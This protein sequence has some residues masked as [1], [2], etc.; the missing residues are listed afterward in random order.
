M[1]R[2]ILLPL[3]TL[4][5]L[6]TVG[7]LWAADSLSLED[8]SF[9]VLG[10][11]ID[12]PPVPIDSQWWDGF[13]RPGADGLVMSFVLHDGDVVVGGDFQGIGS[14]RS[15]GIARW[16]GSDWASL[17]SDFR[18]VRVLGVYDGDVIAG[19]RC[20][21]GGQ[22]IWHWDGSAWQRIG[23][24][25][26]AWDGGPGSGCEG[27]PHYVFALAEY[28]GRLFAG[29]WFGT[30]T[31]NPDS[32]ILQWN[33]ETWSSL[34]STVNAGVY[35]MTL[36][37]GKLVVGGRFTQAGEVGANRIATWDG[38]TWSA[39]G[40]GIDDDISDP[41][42]SQRVKALTVYEGNLYA[43]GVFSKAGSF[44]VDRLA[45]WD[46]SSWNSTGFEA[47][48]YVDGEVPTTN[49]LAVYD[50]NLVAGGRFRQ[51]DGALADFIACWDGESWT[52]LGSGLDG[53]VHALIPFDDV[54]LVGGDFTHAGNQLVYNMAMWDGEAWH[55][56]GYGQGLDRKAKSLHVHNDRLIVGGSFTAAGD[57][58]V[59]RIAGWDGSSWTPLGE[60][61]V[62]KEKSV[63]AL[64][65]YQ[66][67]LVGV[68]GQVV[69]RWNGVS[70][71]TL[72]TKFDDGIRAIEVYNDV[73][74]ASGSVVARWD[75]TTWN[76]FGIPAADEYVAALK[77]S[78]DELVAGGYFTE[79]SG[80][81]ARN[82]AAW[83]GVGWRP[84]GQGLRRSGYRTDYAVSSLEVFDGDLI[85][86]GSFN[87]SGETWV[88]YVAR[89]DG[90]TWNPLGSGLDGGS[91][92]HV[93]DF[94]VYNGT[95]IVG[96]SFRHADGRESW[97]IARWNGSSWNPVGSGIGIY[98]AYLYRTVDNTVD[99]L[100]VY[101]GD[102]YA[103]GDFKYAGGKPSFYIARWRDKFPGMVMNFTATSAD[104]LVRLEWRNPEAEV[105][106]GTIVRYSASDYPEGPADGHPVPNANDGHFTGSA[107]TDTF[108]VH[109]GVTNGITLYYSAFAY[110]AAADY[111]MAAFASATPADSTDPGPVLG[112]TATASPEGV[113]LEWINPSDEDFVETLISVSTT[114]YPTDP[115]RGALH[116]KNGNNGWFE[117]EPGSDSI[118]IDAEVSIGSTYYYTAWAYDE[119][120]NHSVAVHDSAA[121]EY[122]W[123]PDT[124]QF[125]EARAFDRR[126]YLL[127]ANPPSIY[128][129]STHI[130]FSTGGFPLTVT[131]GEPVP[132]A[133]DGWFE[134][135]PGAWDNFFHNGLASGETY[136]YSGFVSLGPPDT[137]SGPVMRAAMPWGPDDVPPDLS[138]GV[139][140]NPYL[141]WYLDLY[142]VG[143]EE[144]DSA[145]I[146]VRVEGGQAAMVMVGAAGNVWRGDYKIV[147]Q[148][149]SISIAACA[150]DLAAN[151]T[152]VTAGLSVGL[153]S[154]GGGG[155]VQSRG[156]RLMLS[157][158]PGT[159]SE[160]AYVLV[161]P[162]AVPDDPEDDHGVT[163]VAPDGEAAGYHL[164][165]SG[166][167]GGRSAHLEMSYDGI[168][169][170]SGLSPD[171]IYIEHVGV[172]P[173]TSYVDPT[174]GTVSATVTQLGTFRLSAGAPGTSNFVD[175]A[176]LG[177]GQAAPNPFSASTVLK[178]EIRAVLKVRASVYD[179]R[180]RH[181]ATLMDGTAYPGWG[182]LVWDGGSRGRVVP[183][184]VYFLKVETPRANST[185]KLVLIR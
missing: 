152:C 49:A 71:D 61:W 7:N 182:N 27:L 103:G 25:I 128:F 31:G 92:H 78:G 181:V 24:G 68:D 37:D 119:S 179:I 150:S 185:I 149:D 1:S 43:G 164:S 11:A 29:G 87:L 139:L 72:T 118:Y 23:A 56:V 33:G 97:N 26:R 133:H 107:G 112:F 114:E 41:W 9:E 45:Y 16:D 63:T 80:T 19:V 153:V 83:D 136:Y 51:A 74:I 76:T 5:I 91:F 18:D 65:T 156:G 117:G 8:M 86:G 159:V 34:G 129:K 110:D 84:L 176:Y 75:G 145:S 151:T 52:S 108:F 93:R 38:S 46:G 48:G 111:S 85:A 36:Y 161:F 101:E 39:L 174:V 146:D 20:T 42:A 22:C 113:R 13:G 50:G 120:R 73:L 28:S 6:T 54:L 105:F 30:Q 154:K 89:W 69:K 53:T 100:A 57:L 44:D 167:L 123:G 82:V 96:G 95:L 47:G 173:L 94:A 14:V 163:Y 171:Q 98:E 115:S 166:L 90:E 141:T 32:H 121:M 62:G 59:I 12:P 131:D 157:V 125:F 66:G 79:I 58:P 147:G 183:S 109:H 169:A 104:T 102:L 140:Q 184:G 175:P 60:G 70:W 137:L 81:E 88:K 155:T 126:V 177:L 116:V 21:C 178:F 124:L 168:D 64:T 135:P 170:L 35:A 142:L 55:P 99:A 67:S 132:N 127:W 17:D 3:F 106:E 162:A 138:I 148:M 77:V 143:S 15:T 130:R 172:G 165:P 158:P 180:G 144:L 134:A 10:G 160:D 4:S 122:A 2:L 40:T